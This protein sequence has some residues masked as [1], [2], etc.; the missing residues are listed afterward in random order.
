MARKKPTSKGDGRNNKTSHEGAA[1]GRFITEKSSS[2]GMAYPKHYLKTSIKSDEGVQAETKARANL[3]LEFLD[4]LASSP[5][6]PR[7]AEEIEA[8]IHAERNAWNE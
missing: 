7:T 1:T 2:I 3:M 4:E 8:D 6:L 5:M